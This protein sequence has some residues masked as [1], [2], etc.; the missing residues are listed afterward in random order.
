MGKRITPCDVGIQ[1]TAAPPLPDL[2]NLF[3]LVDSLLQGGKVRGSL[4]DGG[5]L[6]STE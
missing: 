5:Q 1:I 2:Q 3:D 6:G 4:R